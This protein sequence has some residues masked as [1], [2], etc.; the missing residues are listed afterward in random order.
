MWRQTLDG[1]HSGAAILVH[2]PRRLRN[3]AEDENGLMY[4]SVYLSV[5]YAMLS[6]RKFSTVR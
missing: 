5:V 2:E 4:L 3:W 1:L 6:F